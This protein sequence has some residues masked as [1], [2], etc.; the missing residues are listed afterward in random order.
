[1][2]NEL[3]KYILLKTR[4]IRNLK[5]YAEIINSDDEKVFTISGDY[6]Q[7]V[8][9]KLQNIVNS[10]N[11]VD[12]RGHRHYTQKELVEVHKDLEKLLEDAKKY[13]DELLNG[14][15]SKRNSVIYENI[16]E[17]LNKID[18]IE[19]EILQARKKGQKGIQRL[20]NRKNKF[21]DDL[22]KAYCSLRYD[23]DSAY[24]DM[25]NHD[26][27]N[28]VRND[29][30]D[31]MKTI[32]L[33]K[34]VRIMED[35]INKICTNNID[36]SIINGEKLF[37]SMQYGFEWLFCHNN[38]LGNESN[39][40]YK[41]VDIR[42]KNR[43][44]DFIKYQIMISGN[45]IENSPK[46]SFEIDEH[47][48]LI[49]KTFEKKQ[50]KIK[51]DIIENF[52]SSVIDLI[53][54]F[55]DVYK[56]LIL[57]RDTIFIEEEIRKSIENSYTNSEDLC[58]DIGRPKPN[59]EIVILSLIALRVLIDRFVSFVK[60]N[61]LNFGNST[62]NRSW[63]NYSE[64]SNS[65]YA[66]SNFKY[67]RLENAKVENCDLS[68]CNLSCADGSGSDFSNSNFNY[69]NMT[70][71]DLINASI[72]D[73]QFKNTIFRDADL[74]SYKLPIEMLID[75]VKEDI[76]KED[77]V[78]VSR[79][80]SV[81]KKD[82][83]LSSQKLIMSIC[84]LYENLS[85]PNVVIPDEG[86][87]LVFDSADYLDLFKE[88]S[89][90]TNQL[91]ENNLSSVISSELLDR[92]RELVNYESED[93][94]T[95]REEQHG[96]IL[97]CSANLTRVSAQ[98]ARMSN[99]DFSH[100]NMEF[101]SFDDSDI[102]ESKMFYTKASNILFIRANMNNCRCFETNFESSNFSNSILNKARFINCNLNNTNWNK[103][104]LNG[105]V[106][107]DASL[108]VDGC[109]NSTHEDISLY[110][111]KYQ[112]FNNQI[113]PG[114][115]SVIKDKFAFNDKQNSFEVSNWQKNCCM[116]D[117]NL[118]YALADN[119]KFMN[120]SADRCTFNF[121]AFKNSLFANCS[122]HLSDFN[123][124]DFRYSD[125]VFCSLGQSSF[126]NTNLTNTSIK[127]VEFS[128]ANLSGALFNSA[129]LDH[130]IFDGA[131]LSYINFTNAIIKNSVFTSCNVSNML[132]HGARF[133][134]CIFENINLNSIIGYHSCTFINTYDA[135]NS[136]IKDN[137]LKS[138][139]EWKL[140]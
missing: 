20:Y 9:D 55:F 53:K 46:T 66:G 89:N 34:N 47:D 111:S 95:E 64:L 35:I 73:C 134:N 84:N 137:E 59:N 139:I 125:I 65:N 14:E 49:R 136:E 90:A 21:L 8:Q 75:K 22:F 68:T 87:L 140:K 105:A 100:S 76:D 25:I 38:V 2:R 108:L 3:Q 92:I 6:A 121:A 127:C 74:D 58:H 28:F 4:R 128:E 77:K 57:Y 94:R 85:L 118:M 52:K 24:A 131:D 13:Y 81:W 37:E 129:E 72:N 32:L 120:I 106:F 56:V 113:K 88:I 48:Q 67:S 44:L 97:F 36:K 130:V 115:P 119:S 112:S 86:R 39:K 40:K 69:S 102:S 91:L 60:I 107:I 93:I 61:D 50:F 7:Q 30:N 33:C 98:R 133:E 41:R 54:Q 71:I 70:G 126:K 117:S 109:I 5:S 42:D 10:L 12:R 29:T 31:N 101:A 132:L 11:N 114:F 123:N 83:G 26:N 1:M 122:M 15:S 45:F 103:A 78:R 124:T 16:S 51:L 23:F 99:M 110:L 19:L 62:F 43:F 18:N 63:F 79:L 27:I 116:N 96:K 82:D 17:L 104:I 135:S 138:K 80:L